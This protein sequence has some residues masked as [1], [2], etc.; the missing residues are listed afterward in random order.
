[1][2]LLI[3]SLGITSGAAWLGASCHIPSRH[4][5]LCMPAW[6]P[7]TRFSALLQ[8]VVVHF[9]KR[10]SNVQSVLSILHSFGIVLWTKGK[11][12]NLFLASFT[13]LSQ[14]WM[15]GKTYNLMCHSGVLR[16][17]D[18]ITATLFLV[19]VFFSH[20]KDRE[21]HLLFPSPTCVVLS[22]YLL[23][24]FQHLVKSWG[25]FTQFKNGFLYSIGFQSDFIV[26]K[27]I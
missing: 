27:V 25:R 11:L 5:S 9:R 3:L 10:G 16:E 26:S 14:C 21:Q 13:P 22:H 12:Y 2:G 8:Q 4:E 18:T 17:N 6:L 19:C 20:H 1:M 15:K 24:C 23:T 7:N